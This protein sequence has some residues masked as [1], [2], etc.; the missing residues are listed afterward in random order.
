MQQQFFCLWS[1]SQK[2]WRSRD[3]DRRIRSLS[4]D[5]K[6]KQRSNWNN[7]RKSL[8]IP[9]ERKEIGQR[10]EQKRNREGEDLKWNG[11][12]TEKVNKRDR[13]KDWIEDNEV[14]WGLLKWRKCGCELWM[15]FVVQ[16]RSNR[17]TLVLRWVR[18][19]RNDDGCDATFALKPKLDCDEWKIFKRNASWQSVTILMLPLQPNTLK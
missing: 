19:K 15:N 5:E 14:G 11:P 4:K 10:S 3:L 9:F 13:M 18:V 2:I 6:G 17:S 12:K 7:T 16:Q 1:T 8:N